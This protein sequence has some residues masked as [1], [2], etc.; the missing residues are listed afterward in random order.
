MRILVVSDTHGNQAALLRAHEAA[1][2]CEAIIH[3][4][5]GEEDAALLAVLDE[6]CPVVRLAG[7]CDLGSTAPREL[8]REWAG[9]RLLLCHGDRYGVKGG[10]ARLLEQ[11]RATGVDAVLYGHTH[12]AQAVRQEGIWLINPGTLTAPAPF[13]SYAILELSHAGLQVTIHPLP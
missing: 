12:L 13:H 10:L 6:G 2:R 9:V 1:G 5:D 4:G 7:N 3:L 8:I 11:G